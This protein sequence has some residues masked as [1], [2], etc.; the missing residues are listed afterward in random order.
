M[1]LHIVEVTVVTY[2]LE[3][4]FALELCI[5]KGYVSQNVAASHAKGIPVQRARY[6]GAG[7]TEGA[8]AATLLTE[9]LV[10]LLRAFGAEGVM[11]SI[12]TGCG[13]LSELTVTA[14]RV[15]GLVGRIPLTRKRG[16][17]SLSIRRSADERVC[18]S[19]VGRDASQ[20]WSMRRFVCVGNNPI[21]KDSS[22]GTTIATLVGK[23]AFLA[24]I[25]PSEWLLRAN[26]GIFQA[27]LGRNFLPVSAMGSLLQPLASAV[28]RV[29][30]LRGA[31]AHSDE[32]TADAPPTTFDPVMGHYSQAQNEEA[33]A[34]I[35]SIYVGEAERYDAAVVES[36]KADME[37]MLIFSGLF[38]A[39]LTAFII[40]SYRNLQP[41]SGELTV[42]AISQVSQQLAAIASGKTFVLQAAAPFTPTTESLW[43]NAL[44]FISLA[45][46]LT[47]ALLATLVEQWAREFLHKTEMRPS[48][49]RRARIFSFLYFGLKRFRMHT[50][51]DAIPFLLHASLLL[52]FAG[53]VAFLL[54]VNHIMMY[55]MCIALGA[56]IILYTILTVLPVVQLDC[57]Y[58]TPLSALLWSLLQ[59]PFNFFAPS[60]TSSQRTITEAALDCALQDTKERDQHAL[61]WTIDSLTDDV[62]FLPF[63]EAIP[64]IIHGPNGFRRVNDELFIG[65]LGDTEV[66]SP[67]VTRICNL[68]TGTRGMLRGDPLASRRRNAGFKAL[69]ALC[70]MPCAW[71]RRFEIN[72]GVLAFA[73]DG[74]PDTV[75]LAVLYQRQRWSSHLLGT[76]HELMRHT[77]LSPE[78][79]HEKVLWE[80]HRLLR[81]LVDH[82]DLTF[83]SILEELPKLRALNTEIGDSL[84]TPSQLDSAQ[85][86]VAAVYD[87]HD[88]ASTSTYLIGRFISGG[89][90][91]SAMGHDLDPVF[92]PLI[93][94][95]TILA[96][97]KSSPPREHWAEKITL[98]VPS[99]MDKMEF[100]PTNPHRIDIFAHIAFRISAFW[101]IDPHTIVC[102]VSY[103]IHRRNGK[104][105]RIA[106]IGVAIRSDSAAIEFIDMVLA[107][108]PADL[109]P[110]NS[111]FWVVRNLRRLRQLQDEMEDMLPN[112]GYPYIIFARLQEICQDE[113]L[114]P[115][116]PL[117][118]PKDVD[119][120][121]VIE[122]LK[123]RLLDKQILFLSDLFED[124]RITWAISDLSPFDGF[125]FGFYKS[126]E[127]VDPEIQH[128]MFGA[129]LAAAQHPLHRDGTSKLVLIQQ[130]W[131]S[132][133]FWESW[134]RAP[135][136]PLI[137]G[138]QSVCLPL[139]IQSLELYHGAAEL[140]PE[141]GI[142]FDTTASKKILIAV[143]EEL[144]RQKPVH[145]EHKG[146]TSDTGGQN[147]EEDGVHARDEHLG[148]GGA[149][150]S[151]RSEAKDEG[152]LDGSAEVE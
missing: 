107:G 43:C 133:L 35:W 51:V 141:D 119:K 31:S 79:L 16:G 144:K 130:L 110:H 89:L 98:S 151:D 102:Y 86:I 126:W 11:N 147:V 127:N 47:C 60:E 58:R 50:I 87:R 96:E 9:S 25:D 29:L 93:T 85:K 81:L 140:Q 75:H 101:Q 108:G 84:P 131:S 116:C 136:S 73:G 100:L 70:L 23:V 68:I 28:S 78:H 4:C 15:T 26:P 112:P 138:I 118:L 6:G 95:N 117:F 13:G 113:L 27:I 40:E 122:S 7:G 12:Y 74:L 149:L 104:A 21:W 150:Q 139:L 121:K 148:H 66:A 57:P 36:W 38:S 2:V 152:D 59:N 83:R 34:N 143:R 20:W 90:M 41:D 64:D 67:L 62:E 56:F 94:C 134:D 32:N 125:T 88:W 48:P 22:R 145:E 19:H 65:I 106:I 45:L 24:Q 37:G 63:V 146:G 17:Y 129:V 10:E 76:L 71:N 132:N 18:A 46:S 128:R 1:K 105:I 103:V 97:M 115:L 109:T 49:V 114:C 52:F 124:I 5:W 39:S 14:L 123:D 33:C 92:D 53:L 54:P 77:G 80:V 3:G 44:W 99:N 61:E 137:D 82:T 120:G 8:I 91:T 142:S 42:A 135:K 72:L 111:G 55:L 30:R 69:W